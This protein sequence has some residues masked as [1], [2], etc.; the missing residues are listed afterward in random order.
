MTVRN[1]TKTT[2]SVIII[3]TGFVFFRLYYINLLSKFMQR[4]YTNE[5]YATVIIGK[6]FPGKYIGAYFPKLFYFCVIIIIAARI[7]DA[8]LDRKTAFGIL[9]PFKL[10]LFLTAIITAAICIEKLNIL[11]LWAIFYLCILICLHST[12][13][14]I[15]LHAESVGSYANLK[16]IKRFFLTIKNAIVRVVSIGIKNFSNPVDEI[17]I[18][19]A[20]AIVLLSEAVVIISYIIYLTRHWRLI[21][22]SYVINSF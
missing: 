20:S 9:S 6:L 2:L 4:I 8:I 22:L 12:F 7:I 11:Q 3:I 15:I 21:F 5:W 10:P 16:L 1:I 18:L 19:S 14:R 13:K 17:T